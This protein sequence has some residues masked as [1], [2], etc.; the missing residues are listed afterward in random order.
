[1]QSERRQKEGGETALNNSKYINLSSTSVKTNNMKVQLV[2]IHKTI[3]NRKLHR[4]IFHLPL[5]LCSW[6]QKAWK[7]R[8]T[9][10]PANKGP[11]PHL[12][13]YLGSL[14]S[15]LLL[16]MCCASIGAGRE[17]LVRSELATRDFPLKIQRALEAGLLIFSV[18]C[19]LHNR[20]VVL[21]CFGATPPAGWTPPLLA[22]SKGPLL[23]G[24]AT[25]KCRCEAASWLFSAHQLWPGASASDQGVARV[26]RELLGLN[27]SG[28]DPNQA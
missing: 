24:S 13:I 7:L 15:L 12:R 9:T 8:E 28:K 27:A 25:R 22:A 16:R 17:A 20:N 3:A 21:L 6:K 4:L 2:L 14:A 19:S 26:Q 18:A 1:M 10:I 5:C 11:T 23:E